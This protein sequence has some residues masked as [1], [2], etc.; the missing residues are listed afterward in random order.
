MTDPTP[1]PLQREPKQDSGQRAATVRE[2]FLRVPLASGFWP[3]ARTRSER[4][5][6]RPRPVAHRSLRSTAVLAALLL[7]AT[8]VP[9]LAA[10]ASRQQFL[11]AYKLL[12]RGDEKLAA[13]AFDDYLGDFPRAER[14]GDAAYYRALVHRRA[15]ELAAAAKRLDEAP[16]PT[17]VPMHAV[18]LL[19][20]QV[21]SDLHRHKEAL[22]PLEAIDTAELPDRAAAS[23]RFLRGLTHRAV[24]NLARAEEDLQAAAALDTPLEGRSLLELSRVRVLQDRH[25][26]AR[27][28]LDRALVQGGASVEAEAARLAGELAYRADDLDAAIESYGRVIA[29]HPR[30]THFGP[31]VVGS[32][33]AHLAADRSKRVVELFGQHRESLRLQDLLPATY[34]KGSAH[35]KLHQP[36]AA[37]EAL[38]S[39]ARG[40]GKHPLLE[41]ALY[42]L[43]V[44]RRQLGQHDRARAAVARLA[45][46]YPDS[47]RLADAAFLLALIDAE[48]GNVER[49]AN[50]LN[51]LIEQGPE[52]PYHDQALLRRARLYERH[53]FPTR[54]IEDYQAFLDNAGTTGEQGVAAALRLADLAVEQGRLQLAADLTAALLAQRDRLDADAIQEAMF[55]RSLALIRLDR[56]DAAAEQLDELEA[57][58]PVSDYRSE[59]RYYR[60]LLAANRDDA[61]AALPTLRKAAA[62]E[63]LSTPRRINSLRLLAMLQRDADPA[64]SAEAIERMIELGGQEAVDVSERLWLARRYLA[65]D[66][67]EDALALATPIAASAM[68]GA[69]AEAL[70][71]RGEA[72]R[73]LEQY[74]EAEQSLRRVRALGEG[75]DLEAQAQLAR[76][77]EDQGQHAAAIDALQPLA[78]SRSSRAAA[79]ALYAMA[80]NHRPLA[81]QARRDEDTDAASHHFKQAAKHLK[82][83]VLVYPLQELS[84]LPQ[85]A[86]LDLAEVEMEREEKQAAEREL[87]ELIDKYPD[88]PH[89]RVA[90]AMLAEKEP[91]YGRGLA[92]L[93]SMDTQGL[94]PPLRQRIERWIERW[95]GRS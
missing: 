89:A 91:P 38:A 41:Q 19:A 25:D 17:L 94:D 7:F 43:A 50:R 45:D 31:A 35:L 44:A 54:A 58:Y 52:H 79:E 16:K 27:E 64:A 84:P 3:L 15:G 48:A 63:D 95:E 18:R 12:Q 36:E 67:N 69:L 29:R 46:L 1:H 2:R 60:A 11:F 59:V 56:P 77:L 66:R 42:K 87:Q 22:Q 65:G 23:V 70:L 28:T 10:D 81:R 32:M 73:K 4:L 75:F 13:E 5:A 40:E 51:E 72:L 6:S 78:A 33:W 61:A 85:R 86:Y 14:R 37:A 9:A 57:T 30:S 93:R 8:A 82:K 49:G 90:R 88:T 53:G 55:R 92:M 20:G 34:L 26:A 39:I 68:R 47:P 80:R 74:D 24:G 83:L 21:L 62:D 71:L 76:L